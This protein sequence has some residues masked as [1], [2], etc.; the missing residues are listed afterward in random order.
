MYTLPVFEICDHKGVRKHTHNVM[1]LSRSYPEPLLTRAQAKATWKG[2]TLYTPV[3]PISG[4]CAGP[5]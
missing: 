1:I 5:P 4:N 3:G 2:Y